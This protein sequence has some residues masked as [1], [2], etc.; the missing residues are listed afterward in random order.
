M[1]KCGRFRGVV[2]T[3]LTRVLDTHIHTVAVLSQPSLLDNLV[4]AQDARGTVD[5][6]QCPLL[7][8]DRD[9]FYSIFVICSSD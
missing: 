4:E 2:E 5:T 3:S 6:C 9:H 7:T 1:F 8:G